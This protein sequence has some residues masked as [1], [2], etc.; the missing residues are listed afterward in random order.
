MRSLSH[1]VEEQGS[2]G[3]CGT[4]L[5][6]TL[7]FS[8]CNILMAAEACLLE[9][10]DR[11]ETSL[12]SVQTPCVRETLA[13]HFAYL[14]F[15][16]G[17][18]ATDSRLLYA[19][20][21]VLVLGVLFAFYNKGLLNQPSDSPAADATSPLIR[22]PSCQLLM[23]TLR[24][25]APVR[26]KSTQPRPP[27]SS[28]DGWLGMTLVWLISIATLG[29]VASRGRSTSLLH[30]ADATQSHAAGCGAPDGVSFVAGKGIGLFQRTL[31]QHS[32]ALHH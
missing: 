26:P 19:V 2:L 22:S 12:E 7:A 5:L 3:T 31:S 18:R 10:R 16:L 20:A 1:L 25:P 4:L 32:D 13:K 8:A 9:R 11:A 23:S 6:G 21:K 27:A 29:Q 28:S 14:A 24:I 30:R 17:A 15:L